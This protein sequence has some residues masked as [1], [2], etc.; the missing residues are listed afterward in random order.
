[1]L[2]LTNKIFPQFMSLQHLQLSLSPNFVEFVSPDLPS[3]SS[4][5]KSLRYPGLLGLLQFG[6]QLQAPNQKYLETQVRRVVV[7]GKCK[8]I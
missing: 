5:K 7:H 8:S 2:E 4:I 6:P 1:V 3:P